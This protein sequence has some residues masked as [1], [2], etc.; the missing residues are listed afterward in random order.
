MYAEFKFLFDLTPQ[1]LQNNNNTGDIFGDLPKGYVVQY[2]GK[3]G[4]SATNHIKEKVYDTD[5]TDGDPYI[6][7]INYFNGLSASKALKIKASDLAY[8]TDL[9]VYPINRLIILRRF[10]AGITV[11]NN[12]LEW[13]SNAFEPISTVIG[14]AKEGADEWFNLSFNE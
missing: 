2:K 1:Q 10:P 9:G 3:K 6:G 4:Q 8:L 14:W 5:K 12:L 13:G 11:P 7:L